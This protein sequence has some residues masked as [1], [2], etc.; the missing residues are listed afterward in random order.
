MKT[1]C[2]LI[3]SL[4]FAMLLLAPFAGQ[5]QRSETIAGN[6]SI[7]KE[8]RN[9]SAEVDEI[10]TS[11]KFKVYVTQGN[12]PSIEVEADENLLPYIETV[13]EGDEL[14]LHPK[15]GFNIK[16]SNDIIVRVTVRQLESLAGSG[17]TGFYSQGSIKGE[18]LEIALSGKGDAEMDLQYK[19]LEVAISGT[20]KAKLAGRAD[21]TEF[22]ISGSGDID[23]PE[24]KSEE[25][26]VSISGSGS[27]F[28]NASKKL[29]VAVSGSGNVKYKGSARVN[30]MISGKGKIEQVN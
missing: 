23:A 26:E 7:K 14:R 12:N 27:A 4:S 3:A 11:G 10:S 6:G 8:K 21:N 17:T 13:I 20:G 15:R 30:Q 2:R 29:D 1:T 16:P 24:M 19:K 28:V 9:A 18:K 22:A 25:M 5:A